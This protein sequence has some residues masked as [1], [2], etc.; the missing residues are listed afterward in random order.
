MCSRQVQTAAGQQGALAI[1]GRG[2]KLE[3]CADRPL[4]CLAQG[5]IAK[6]PIKQAVESYSGASSSQTSALGTTLQGP[7][8]ASL[9]WWVKLL[10]ELVTPS[11]ALGDKHIGPNSTVSGVLWLGQNVCEVALMNPI[12]GFSHRMGFLLASCLPLFSVFS[13][14]EG[15]G[16]Q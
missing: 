9:T 14:R 1:A 6:L 3:S 5:S 8:L 13:L 12:P 4:L 16:A 7:H 2:R 11:C 15:E 10:W